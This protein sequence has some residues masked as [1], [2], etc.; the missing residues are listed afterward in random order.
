MFAK[1]W[2]WTVLLFLLTNIAYA[3][4]PNDAILQE[5]YLK[6]GMQ[7]QVEQ[8]PLIIRASFDQVAAGD[9]QIQ[10]LPANLVSSMKRLAPE[11]FNPKSLKNIVL[12]ELKAKLMDSEVKEV[13]KWLDSPIGIKITRLEEAASTPEAFNE[14]QQYVSQLQKAPPSPQRL[15]IL[16]N[17]DSAVKGNENAVDIAINTQI[18]I[19][20]AIMATFPLEQQR[21]LDDVARE[22]EKNRPAIEAEVRAQGFISMLYAYRSLTEEEIKRYTNFLTSPAGSKYQSV[23]TAAFK[24]AFLEGSVKW[25]KAIGQA[26]KQMQGQSE[27]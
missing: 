8:V 13:L 1:V 10:K 24:K 22:M 6:S 19:T 7:K 27:T 23:A 12:A 26:I 21:P 2:L 25:G 20:L 17:L 18:A 16:R 5:L 11:A 15:E 9:D 4:N 3:Q 14:M